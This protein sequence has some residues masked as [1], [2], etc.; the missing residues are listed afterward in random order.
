MDRRDF[1]KMVGVGTGAA[2]FGSEIVNA[3]AAPDLPQML[4]APAAAT[5]DPVAHVLNRL[6]FGPRPGQVDAVK[7]MGVQAFLDQQLNPQTI[8]DDAVEQRLGNYITLGM[9]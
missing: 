5:V 1:L 4:Q 9:M 7:K 8:N 3:L 2:L 6:T